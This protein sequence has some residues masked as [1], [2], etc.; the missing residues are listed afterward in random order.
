MTTILNMQLKKPWDEASKSADKL[1]LRFQELAKKSPATTKDFITMANAITPMIASMGGGVDK[2]ERITQGA[3]IAGIATG[4]R[5]DVASLDVKQMLAG[6]VTERDMMANQL[7]ASA[8]MKKEDFNDLSAGARGAMTEKLLQDPALM[9]AADEFGKSFAGQ[10]STFKDQLQIALGSVGKPLMAS[11]SN[12]V[13]KWNTWIEKHPKTIAKIARELGSMIKG[14]FEFVAQTVGWLVE[15]RDTLFAIGKTFLVFKGASLA[16]N[17]FKGFAD[18]IKGFVSQLQ[19]AKT[20]L[21][22]AVGVGGGGI[23][24]AFKSLGG[25]ITGAGGVLPAFALLASAVFEFGGLM[26]GI[27]D[28]EKARGRRGDFDEALGVASEKAMRLKKLNEDYFAEGTGKHSSLSSRARR[29]DYMDNA[30]A[31]RLKKERATLL[32]DMAKPEVMGP[33]LRQLSDTREK[34]GLGSLKEI[35]LEKDLPNLGRGGMTGSEFDALFADNPNAKK[36]MAEL[37]ETYKLF[38]AL[39]MDQKTAVFQAAFPEQFDP[40][41]A[42]EVIPYDPAAG[43]KDPDA[44]KKTDVKVTINKI[45]VASEDPDRFVFGMVNAFK[46]VAS[47]PTQAASALGD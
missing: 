2:I 36:L 24:G 37:N 9:K 25:I 8:G 15:H 45:E 29:I 6:T 30:T 14:T 7:L 19:T 46:K 12:E 31:D 1:F 3:V 41:K 42:G 40:A 28:D 34:H 21:G 43:W 26:K 32:A 35:N 33:I 16:T 20:M 38:H 17:A 44:G 11:M 13:Q 22:G 10:V 39:T 27:N 47:N 4:T 23:V 5:A 18:G